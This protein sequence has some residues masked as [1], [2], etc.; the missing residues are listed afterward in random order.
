MLSGGSIADRVSALND[1]LFAAGRA[2]GKLSAEAYA[3]N[4]QRSVI[5]QERTILEGE[6]GEGGAAGS[7]FKPIEYTPEALKFIE[8]YLVQK[9]LESQGF[10]NVSGAYNAKAAVASQIGTLLNANGSG[11][12]LLA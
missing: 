12:N 6:G 10:G 9:D 8:R 7:F 3:L 1:A 4:V 5:T 11:L 2:Q